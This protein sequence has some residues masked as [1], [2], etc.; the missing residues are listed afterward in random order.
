VLL[1]LAACATTPGGPAVDD[2]FVVARGREVSLFRVTPTGLEG[3]EVVFRHEG[4]TFN[5]PLNTFHVA[6]GV[7]E[8][9]N[10]VHIDVQLAPQTLHMKGY[11][12][13]CLIDLTL[14]PKAL[15]GNVC[16]QDVDL[17]FD[18]ESYTGQLQGTSGTGAT[19]R[20]ISV[21]VPRIIVRYPP[22]HL[23]F[24]LLLTWMTRGP[25]GSRGLPP[26]R[27]R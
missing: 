17:G 26:I 4:D 20:G 13:G 12:T 15:K 16:G 10:G 8:A 5:G 18:G 2:T 6:A 11:W 25:M 9:K 22:E 21:H 7:V 14:D 1:L 27:V 19:A 3:Q 23:A 24:G